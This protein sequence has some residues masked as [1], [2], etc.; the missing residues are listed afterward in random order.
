MS[1]ILLV[2][3]DE[4]IRDLVE[5]VAK[6]QGHSFCFS[7][8]GE[9]GLVLVDREKPDLIILDVML[10]GMNGFDLCRAIRKTNLETPIIFLSAKG[11]IVDKSVGFNAGADDY[12]VK[13]F[14]V[15]ELSLRI[16]AHLR[17]RSDIAAALVKSHEKRVLRTGN[18]EI[19]FDDYEVKQNGSSLQLSSKEFEILSLL[20]SSPGKVFTREQIIE[21]LWGDKNAADPS[22]VTVFLRK[23]REKIEPDP[24]NPRYLQTVWRVGYKFVMAEDGNGDR[25]D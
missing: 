17:R 15:D 5:R 2:D 14:S 20:A 23:I 25:L 3:D 16:D 11:D 8:E 13:P 6:R 1:K 12:I 9:E 10:P 19:T 18:L 21:Y 4:S 22:S 7:I 24:A